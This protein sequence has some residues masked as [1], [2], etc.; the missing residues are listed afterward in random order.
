MTATNAA[1]WFATDGY[2]PVKK[3]IN[4]RRVA[5]ESFLRGFFAHG[6]VDEYVSF[7]HSRSDHAAFADLARACG[8]TAPLRGVR[9]DTPMALR[10]VDVVHYPAPISSTELWRRAPQ[11]AAAWALCG[12]THTT[13]T[14]NVMQCLFD[15]R[16]APQMPWD[17]V[18][19]TSKAVQAS[20]R[21]LM[22]LAEAHLSQR[23][24]G[25][26]LPARPLLPVIP[27]GVDCAAFQPD[28]A[29][30]SALRDRI[31][32]GPGDLVAVSIARLTPDEKFDP[33][34]LFL[35]MEEAAAT[36]RA[37][38]GGKLHLALCGQFSEPLWQEIFATAAARLMPSCGYRLL[39]GAD[40]A[41]RRATLSG[42]DVFVFPI[43][44][45]QE[46]FGL[47]PVEAMA[48]GLPVIVSDWD[49]MKDTVTPDVGFRIPTELPRTGV[50]SYVS[51]RY[52]GGTDSYLQYLSQLSAMTPIDVAA[53]A[54]ALATLA[55]DPALRARMGA[56]ARDRAR[57]LYDWSAVIPQMQALW[58]EQ[59]AMLAH[60]RAKGGPA[61]AP[62]EAG[63]IPVG[64]AVEEMFAAYPTAFAAP[65]RRLAATGA[66]GRPS[67]AETFELRNY[68]ARRRLLEDPARIETILAAYAATGPGGA[69]EAEIA[70]ATR[71]P[72]AMIARASLWLLK[73]HFLQQVPG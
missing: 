25:A 54:R 59:A 33:L 27:L 70:A 11:G 23:F 55:R 7:A 45:L 21:R 5:G 61:L 9:L 42:G 6:E 66:S 72:A 36:W 65:D 71:L 31:G 63:L 32:A 29:A 68:A 37:E 62:R 34:P 39:D 60:A 13:A 28:A 30:G 49:G 41:E 19:C 12:I 43:D 24:S 48:A 47:A 69:T 3:G 44:N 58:G 40:P 10:P 57:R 14:R 8:V 15:L 38:G 56:A 51:H 17:A 46:T 18:I 1:I 22:E 73:Y 64:P 35:A 67:A 52:L 4:G 26:I 53:L 20:V 2:D 50:S 16:S